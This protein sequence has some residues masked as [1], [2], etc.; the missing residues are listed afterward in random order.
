MKNPS[1]I[2]G[3]LD[4]IYLPQRHGNILTFI[5]RNRDAKYIIG[6]SFFDSNKILF[7]LFFIP[8]IDIFLYIHSEKKSGLG[9]ILEESHS[10][11]NKDKE[12]FN[13][14]VKQKMSL[15]CTLNV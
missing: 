12:H 11:Q 2:F 8:K 3:L 15:L 6:L 1:V 7:L 13:I 5:I 4:Q 10:Y 14:V 9:Y